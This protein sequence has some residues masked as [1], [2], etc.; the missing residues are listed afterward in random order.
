M[1]CRGHLTSASESSAEPEHGRALVLTNSRLGI[2]QSRS[3]ANDRDWLVRG[4][5]AVCDDDRPA[6]ATPLLRSWARVEFLLELIG[7]NESTASLNGT[8]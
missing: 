8:A 3:S 4:P 6:T 2:D 5:T 7:H 1:Q